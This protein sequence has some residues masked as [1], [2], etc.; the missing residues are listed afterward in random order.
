MFRGKVDKHLNTQIYIIRPCV[1]PYGPEIAESAIKFALTNM[2]N[3][4][5]IYFRNKYL[6][7]L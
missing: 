5:A 1:R 6:A 4:P 2:C 7:Y 3:S